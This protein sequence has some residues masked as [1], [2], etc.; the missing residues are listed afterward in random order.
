MLD[1][2]KLRKS[3]LLWITVLFIFVVFTFNGCLT[4]RESDKKAIHE[5]KK[6]GIELRFETLVINKRHL[7][8]AEVGND[9]LPTLVFIHGSP[10]GWIEFKR[11]LKDTNLVGK[12]RIISVDRP[13]FGY[14]DYGQAMHLQPQADIIAEFLKKLQNQKPIYLIGHSYGGPLVA[15]LAADC[16]HIVSRIVILAGALD[17]ALEP[18]E[19]WRTFFIKPPFRYLMPGSVKQANEELW[20]LKTDLFGLK[21]KLPNIICPVFALHAKNDMLVDYR[22]TDF[23][24]KEMVSSVVQIITFKSGNHFIHTNKQVQ[25]DSLLLSFL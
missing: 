19:K 15:L 5:F 1:Y 12:F 21:A 17:P 2:K 13:G 8:Y 3:K 18:K 10:G 9:S 25:I 24:K 7:H 16:P 4:F 23:I 11:F 6:D 14:S 20:Y 22:N